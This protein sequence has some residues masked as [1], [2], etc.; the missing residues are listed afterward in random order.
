M[1]AFLSNAATP[2]LD[3]SDLLRFRV[4]PRELAVEPGRIPRTN[5]DSIDA[6]FQ[7][8]VAHHRA[9]RH[10]RAEA[11]Y[12][13]VLA[14]DNR[15]AD[16]LHML[17]LVALQDGRNDVAVKHIEEAVRIRPTRAPYYL[18]LGNALWNLGDTAQAEASYRT[19]IRVEPTSTDAH[20][21]LGLLLRSQRRLEEAISCYR[22]V[23]RIS[24]DHVAAHNNMGVA[25]KNLSRFDEAE[26]CFNAALR[27]KPD[28]TAALS[29][30]GF[31]LMF[32]GRTSEA[33]RCYREIV[34][35]E[36]RNPEAHLNLAYLLLLTGRLRE[37]WDEY[38]WRASVAAG[39]GGEPVA[40]RPRW[41]GGDVS[42]R[43]VLI[44]AEQGLG[45]TLQF[46]RYVPLVARMARRV[47][48]EVQP[49]LVT[50]LRGLEGIESVVA[51][52]DPLPAFDYQCPLLSLP[53]IM[54]TE[55][56]TIPAPARYLHAD[57]ALAET[58]AKRLGSQRG[59]RIGLTWAGN[60]KL[61]TSETDRRRSL[62]PA[63]LAPLADLPDVHWV[64]LQKRPAGEGGAT[65]P[66]EMRMSDLMEEVSDFAD[67]AA[68]VANLDLIISVDTSVAHLAGALGKP[69]WLLN[70]FDTDWRWL[71]G[72]DDS[73][74]Y[75][76]LR[77]FRQERPGDWT[78][79]VERVREALVS[80]CSRVLAD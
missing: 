26:A 34:R 54:G 15:H 10:R 21:N 8:A 52:G 41:T 1:P 36:P 3:R 33:E 70:R 62:D 16:S 27:S 53:R 40:T 66:R 79:V 14:V 63:L 29:N 37:G 61:S 72:R 4:A 46:C 50:L 73:P 64:S 12:R 69:I 65:L 32:T 18:D 45:D 38:E 49:S 7:E 48:L 42:A 47:V 56:G 6:L 2:L 28:Y 11:L 71:L 5:V 74:W 78:G 57:P 35:R 60:S 31:V 17:G 13:Q 43:S 67:T 20:Y 9:G 51:R 24:P 39:R 55:T 23:V 75:P 30:L 22:E 25:L 80:L 44:H 68:I 58:W 76:S 77:Q 59:M 19:A